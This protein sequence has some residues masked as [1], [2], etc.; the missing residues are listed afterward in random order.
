MAT[1]SDDRPGG[2]GQSTRRA[3]LR[4]KAVRKRLLDGQAAA[5]RI[6]RPTTW[7]AFEHALPPS[8]LRPQRSEFGDQ[9]PG[10]HSSRAAARR[11][12]RLTAWPGFDL[13]RPLD[14]QGRGSGGFEHGRPLDAQGHGA[15][16]FKQARPSAAVRAPAR[17]PAEADVPASPLCRRLDLPGSLDLDRSVRSH[18]GATR[19]VGPF[20]N[21]AEVGI[22]EKE[23]TDFGRRNHMCV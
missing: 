3:E 13:G 14:G 21:P 11:M 22:S 17:R 20:G 23:V 12:R 16:A 15:V 8:T 6:R 19:T 1:W 5:Q 4:T 10:G 9:R 2:R 18:D 7:Q